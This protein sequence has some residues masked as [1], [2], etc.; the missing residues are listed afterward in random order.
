MTVAEQI[1]WD[2]KTNGELVIKDKNDKLIYWENSNGHWIK[3]EYD[4]QGKEIYYEDSD[5]YWTKH[6]YDSK[7]N[8]IYWEDSDGY[9]AKW[10]WDC[11][12]NQTYFEDSDGRITDNRPKPCEVKIVEIEGI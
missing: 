12:G 9:W 7:D 3:R 6:E 1:K 4:F 11:E 10:K 2:F 5:G 8:L